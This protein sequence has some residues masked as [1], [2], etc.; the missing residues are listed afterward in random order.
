MQL[1]YIGPLCI[2]ADQAYGKEEGRYIT[3]CIA[4]HQLGTIGT[5]RNPLRNP[6]N[7]VPTMAFALV[8]ER[9]K[10]K[11]MSAWPGKNTKSTFTSEYSTII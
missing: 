7:S 10:T 3:L 9:Y 2:Q 4:D 11:H 1:T 8:T 6:L 5:G